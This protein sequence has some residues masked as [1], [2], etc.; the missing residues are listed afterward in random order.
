[1][2][3][4]GRIAA[5]IAA[6]LAAAVPAA[7]IAQAQKPGAA[8]D[9]ETRMQ[10]LDASNAEGEERLAEKNGVIALCGR[11]YARD[12]AIQRLVKEC[13]K[14]VEQPVVKQQFA[15]DCMLAAFGYA[16]ALRTLKSEH[17][18]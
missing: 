16:N 14:Y 17:K 11:Q 3:K 10:A 13:A 5:C 18:K 8:A 6:V 4:A 15:A 7:A 1:M 2:S 12:T 9:C